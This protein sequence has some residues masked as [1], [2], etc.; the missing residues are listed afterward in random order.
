[1]IT[2]FGSDEDHPEQFLKAFKHPEKPVN[3]DLLYEGFDAAVDW[4]VIIHQEEGILKPIM[5]LI[6]AHG[7]VP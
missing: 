3:W 5:Y 2:T 4:Y 7:G 1:M 6:Q